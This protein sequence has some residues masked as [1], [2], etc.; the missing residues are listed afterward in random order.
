MTAFALEKLSS[1]HAVDRFDCGV[2][3]L[4]KYLS[5]FALQNQGA[6]AAQNYVALA[7]GAVVGFYTLAVGEVGHSDAAERLKKGLARHPI[8]VMIIARLGIDRRWQGQGLG[9]D[10]LRDAIRRTLAAAE[11]AGIRAIVVHA[12]DE[13][14][15]AF[16]AKHGFAPSPT[17]DLHLYILIKDVPR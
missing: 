4:N 3:A 17:D 16:Y 15:R 1:R 7:D 8:P 13:R 9:A 11:I 10:L 2:E 6:N 5:R 14:A 12:K